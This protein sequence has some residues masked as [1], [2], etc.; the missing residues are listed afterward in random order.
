MLEIAG[1]NKANIDFKFLLLFFYNYWLN[2]EDF[3]LNVE[4]QLLLL[5]MYFPSA[6]HSWSCTSY[7]ISHFPSEHDLIL[8]ITL[9]TRK[10]VIPNKLWGQGSH[11]D[12]QAN[13]NAHINI[14]L[15]IIQVDH[16]GFW[17][18]I[19]VLPLVRKLVLT[20]FSKLT[21]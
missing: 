3:D 21:E 17:Y 12:S 6:S 13:K 7:Y 18:H 2:K 16:L 1:N 14:T 8:C 4:N 10:T 9:I 15:I 5:A 20:I 11:L 19:C